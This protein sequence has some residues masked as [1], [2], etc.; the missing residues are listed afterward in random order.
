MQITLLCSFNT[1]PCQTEA[2]ATKPMAT[3]TITAAITREHWQNFILIKPMND[4]FIPSP[5]NKNTKNFTK[6]AYTH[7]Q[8]YI[9]IKGNKTANKM[10]KEI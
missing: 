8:T 3:T 2:P 6:H 4:I 7:I 10:H 9:K 1:F 5:A